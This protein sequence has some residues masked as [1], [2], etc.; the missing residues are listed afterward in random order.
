[1]VGERL[2]RRGLPFMLTGSFALAFYATPRMTRDL[3]IVVALATADV[4]G[5]VEE[6]APEFFIDADMAREAIQQERMFNLMHFESGIKVDLIVRKRAAYRLAEFERRQ[7]VQVAG[8]RTWIVSRED[9]VL[10]KLV[11]ALETRSEQQMRDIASL[12]AG[13]A[14]LGYIRH[15]ASTL[16]VAAL[17]DEVVK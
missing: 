13:P 14:D 16:G 10:S 4:E 1:M 2:E 15:W 17:L 3:D 6:F 8:L 5:L 12:L 9:L 11:W 7:P